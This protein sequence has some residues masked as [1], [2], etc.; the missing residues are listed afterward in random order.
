MKF[1]FNS[2]FKLNITLRSWQLTN[3]V[4][5]DITFQNSLTF[6]RHHFPDQI[7]TKFQI[8][9]AV[10]YRFSSQQSISPSH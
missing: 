6:P 7:N 4:T 10:A 3:L 9:G 8:Y 5:T 1:A 2:H